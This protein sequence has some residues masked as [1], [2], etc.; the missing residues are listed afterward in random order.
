MRTTSSQ[1]VAE[2]LVRLRAAFVSKREIISESVNQFE[3]HRKH[4]QEFF[5]ENRGFDDGVQ[6]LDGVS[7]VGSPA[8]LVEIYDEK[9]GLNHLE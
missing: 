3:R 5:F 9:R 2:S 1:E 8:I 6:L 7:T 4:W